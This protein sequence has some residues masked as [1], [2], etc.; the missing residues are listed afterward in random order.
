MPLGSCFQFSTPPGLTIFGVKPL[1]APNNQAMNDR[2]FSGS[3]R[4]I[5]S[6]T[7]WLLPM[8]TKNP[9][10]M[11]GVSSNSSWTCRAASGGI[12]ASNAV[13]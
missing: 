12:A 4:W 11:Q 2:S 10:S 8:R 9:L 13:V 1:A 7:K 6:M 3:L 5:D